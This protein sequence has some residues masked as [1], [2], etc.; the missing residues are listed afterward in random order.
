[1]EGQGQELGFVKAKID[2]SVIHPSR[3]IKRTIWSIEEH[4][5][6]ESAPESQSRWYS[7]PR[8]DTSIPC[9]LVKVKRPWIHR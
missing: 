6:Q 2:V 9:T 5:E 4:S 3:G 7:K 8:G 1:M